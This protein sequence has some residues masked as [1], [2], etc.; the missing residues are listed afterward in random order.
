MK[1]KKKTIKKKMK[2][3]QKKRIVVLVKNK[4]QKKMRNL[5]IT[6]ALHSLMVSILLP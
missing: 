4:I 2:K 6:A 5:V 1:T 3:F